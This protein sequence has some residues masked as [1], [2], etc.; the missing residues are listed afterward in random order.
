MNIY[1]LMYNPR[2]PKGIE[3]KK[4]YISGGGIA[5]LAAA[6]F[7]VSDAH[8]PGENITVF[9]KNSRNGGGCM[10]G[11]HAPNG[12]GYINPGERELEPMMECLWYLCSKIP[13][14][15]EEGRTVLD[16]TVES[17]RENAIH[18]ECR[19]LVDQ[20]HI[21]EGI[22]DFKLDKKTSEKFMQFLSEP[23]KNL[24]NITIEDY[25]GKDS[26]FFKSA[27]WMV[28]HSMLAFKPYHSALES[29]RY[30]TRFGIATRIDYDEGILHLKRN[31]Y[32]SLIH[33]IV[34]YLE[35]NGVKFETG[36][37]VY[38]LDMDEGCNIVT[39]IHYKQNGEDRFIASTENDLFFITNGSMLTNVAYGDNTHIAPTNMDIED[40][41]CFDVWRNLAK[42]HEKFGHPEKF[43]GQ[44]DKTK[45][46]S[47]F[48]TVKDYPEFFERVE[49]MTG[50]RS[51]TGGIITFGDSSWDMSIMFYDR[52]YFKDQK[53]N[54]CDVFWAYG[55]FGERVGDYIKKP[56]CE[57][58]GNEI[59]E[60]I[61]YHLG[62]LDMKDEVLS[63]CYVSTAMMPYITSQFM[64]RTG[65]DRPR[66]IPE[67]YKNLAFIGQYV[68]VDA[69]VV[70][71]V[72]TSV[73]T[74][75]QAVYGL[76]GLEK[77]YIEVFPARY[78]MRYQLELIKKVN[79]I[80]PSA[81]L[82]PKDLPEISLK[83]LFGL[84]Q[85]ICAYVNELPPF[86]TMYQ[87]K[88]QSVPKKKS[89]LNPGYP[90]DGKLK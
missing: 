45:W 51:G 75:L 16:E 28:Y 30:L 6:V 71:T 85:K 35:S 82:T 50:S 58:T 46:V 89:V 77:D 72:E 80:D 84:K 20:G 7:L 22:H 87:G 40:L 65:L 4:A 39:G 15:E 56:M 90:Q 36:A 42:K 83:D 79:G 47:V 57:C 1:R 23:E 8:M 68:E 34:N 66:I 19:V 10:D 59:M 44:I 25:F 24:E 12:W 76:I 2:P 3:S 61:L 37:S 48:A 60:E 64:P 74:P 5:G 18:T 86:Y 11:F 69:D 31:E 81:K 29:Q 55:L 38:D 32:D 26:P 13:S 52:D 63:H 17:N 49:K 33:P 62:M 43:I 67:G 54:N 41:G 27:F 73:R 9:E 70:F 88:D 21:W 78:D 53:E 14:L